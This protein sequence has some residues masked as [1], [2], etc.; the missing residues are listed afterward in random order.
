MPVTQL[1]GQKSD[2]VLTVD[3]G[4]PWFAVNP[5]YDSCDQSI[6]SLQGH[7]S[8]PGQQRGKGAPVGSCQLPSRL[9]K[10]P[11]QEPGLCNKKL[12]RGGTWARSSLPTDSD[13][14]CSPHLLPKHTRSHLCHMSV[15]GGTSETISS[16]PLILQTRTLRPRESTSCTHGHSASQRHWAG[17][18]PFH[19]TSPLKVVLGNSADS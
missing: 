7:L 10:I 11:H 8:C 1:Q 18:R 12:E 19:C 3:S 13:R 2:C 5:N 14:P 9:V 6:F 16:K 17:V 4:C 15:L